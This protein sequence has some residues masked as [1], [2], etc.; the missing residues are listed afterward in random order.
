MK[1]CRQT[2]ERLRKILRPP[3]LPYSFAG[4]S[5]EG[6]PHLIFSKS[7]AGLLT[8]LRQKAHGSTGRLPRGFLLNLAL[9]KAQSDCISK[10]KAE[11]IRRFYR[12]DAFRFGAPSTDKSEPSTSASVIVL[13]PSL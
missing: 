6:Q 4:N 9:V 10:Q 3:S 1:D 7:P 12:V 2:A 13:E 11:R 5:K 8:A